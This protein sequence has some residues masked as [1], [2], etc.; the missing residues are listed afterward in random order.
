ML[1]KKIFFFLKKI[2][3]FNEKFYFSSAFLFLKLDSTKQNLEVGMVSPKNFVGAE[4]SIGIL[5]YGKLKTLVSFR[6]KSKW[7]FFHALFSSKSV[8]ELNLNSTE[9]VIVA[10][11]NYR[12]NLNIISKYFSPPPECFLKKN[13]SSVIYLKKRLFKK[14]LEINFNSFIYLKSKITYNLFIFYHSIQSKV[15]SLTVFSIF[16][17][18]Y[19]L[20]IIFK[21][22][23]IHSIIIGLIC[24]IKWNLRITNSNKF[25]FMKSLNKKFKKTNRFL[26]KINSEYNSITY[27]IEK[28]IS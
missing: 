3:L 2:L 13:K 4:I 25:P 23:F 9:S 16:R 19:N 24:F 20:K 28:S 6:L 12:I 18:M 1:K 5:N 11:E 21:N 22:F 10:V 8:E 27:P 26:D 14:N 7:Q 15:R 17:K